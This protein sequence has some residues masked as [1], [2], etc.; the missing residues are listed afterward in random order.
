MAQTTEKIKV[1]SCSNCIL[2]DI[3]G[4]SVSWCN[5]D[6]DICIEENVEQDTLNESCPLKDSNVLIE[7]EQEKNKMFAGKYRLKIKPEEG[8][9][10]DL[11]NS[12]LASGEIVFKDIKKPVVEFSNLTDI[13]G[14]TI[15]QNCSIYRVCVEY[16]DKSSRNIFKTEEQATDSLALSMYSQLSLHNDTYEAFCE[17][18]DSAY[19]ALEIFFGDLTP[20][21]IAMAKLA[22]LRDE[23]NG[24]WKP[25]WEDEEMRKVGI[26]F[27]ENRIDVDYFTHIHNFLTFETV[28]IANKF[29]ENH[30]DLIMAAKPLL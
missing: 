30:R 15:F 14:Y 26:R 9:E 10:I 20:A 8:K 12:N 28:G 11:E 7:L 1:K 18:I 27:Y 23:V 24:D 21:H 2:A 25:D 6:T 17:Y 29:R 19:H 22:R 13:D 4:I 16:P 3:S 5:Y